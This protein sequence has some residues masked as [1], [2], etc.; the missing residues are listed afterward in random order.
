MG[1]AGMDELH[2]WARS[3]G[4]PLPWKTDASFG[5]AHF[6]FEKLQSKSLTEPA[7]PAE[8]KAGAASA[9][10]WLH[11][12]GVTEV[13]GYFGPIVDE[14]STR[15]EETIYETIAQGRCTRDAVRLAR[16]RLTL[17]FHGSGAE[18]RP[19]A[20]RSDVT[21]APASDAPAEEAPSSKISCVGSPRRRLSSPS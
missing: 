15:A 6:E 4:A 2:G 12:A 19:S 7:V 13:V 14:L 18:H 1:T 8:G 11:K 10:V 5:L 21:T 9:A 3:A 20:T 16:Q 17:P